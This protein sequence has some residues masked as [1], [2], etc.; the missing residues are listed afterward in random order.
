MAFKNLKDDEKGKTFVFLVRHGDFDFPYDINKPHPFNPHWPLNKLGKKQAKAVAGEFAKIKGHIGVFYSSS[1]RR[2]EETARE[3]EK[4]IGKKLQLSEKLWEINGIVLTRKYHSP[5]FWR[6][7]MRFRE[8]INEFDRI[9]KK[10]SGEVILIVAHGH[11]IRSILLKKQGLP[12]AK[13]LKDFYHNCHISLLRFNGTKLEKVH[14]F[15][16]K[17]LPKRFISNSK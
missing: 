1:M 5:K 11:L 13:I 15:N 7:W 6:S 4:K 17:E 8:R 2:A 14:F 3:I 16:R 9:L 10:H 12:R